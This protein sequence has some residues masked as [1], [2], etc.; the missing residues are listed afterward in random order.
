MFFISCILFLI[1]KIKNPQAIL[2]YKKKTLQFAEPLYRENQRLI[3][4]LST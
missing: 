2:L 4:G 1:F 3:N